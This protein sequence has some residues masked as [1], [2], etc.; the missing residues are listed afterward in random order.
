MY[1]TEIKHI[2]LVVVFVEVAT[3]STALP[4]KTNLPYEN[5]WA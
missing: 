4:C 5:C 3:G 1:S 2:T